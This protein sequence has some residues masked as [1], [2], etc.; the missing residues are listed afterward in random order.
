[1]DYAYN[2][3][4]I[5][6]R[7]FRDGPLAE[8]LC[9]YDP[10]TTAF[11]KCYDS[12]DI[13]V[14]ALRG[15]VGEK[16]RRLLALLKVMNSIGLISSVKLFPRNAPAGV[17]FPHFFSLF[18][19]MRQEGDVLNRLTGHRVVEVPE[20]DELQGEDYVD[21]DIS[22]WNPRFK[23]HE[24]LSS[25]VFEKV[26]KGT[27]VSA[28]THYKLENDRLMKFMEETS[29]F[30]N[31]FS[32]QAY[33][34]R[35][36]NW[37]F[38]DRSSDWGINKP[39][40]KKL[41]DALRPDSSNEATNDSRKQ[42]AVHLLNN[43]LA[44]FMGNSSAA[45]FVKDF[46]E[47]N[48][49]TVPVIRTM[50]KE[51]V[52]LTMKPYFFITINA[53]GKEKINYWFD[54]WIC[55]QDRAVISNSYFYPYPIV[56]P[57]CFVPE[58]SGKY[59]V[60]RSL[61]DFSG[62]PWTV[63]EL[64]EAGNSEH[65]KLCIKHFQ[66]IIKQGFCKEKNEADWTY[67]FDWFSYICQSKK[68]SKICV[69][70]KTQQGIGKG[71]VGKIFS[72]IFGDHAVSMNAS[73]FFSQFMSYIE[74]LK[75]ILL[76]ELGSTHGDMEMFRH[77][78]TEENSLLEGKFKAKKSADLKFEIFATT[79]MDLYLWKGWHADT[80][81]FFITEGEMMNAEQLKAWKS[82]MHQ[83]WIDILEHPLYDDLGVKA[84]FHWLISRDLSHF[85]PINSL[86]IT[87][88]LKGLMSDSLPVVHKWWKCVLERQTLIHSQAVGGPINDREWLWTDLYNVFTGDTS[89][90]RVGQKR[91]ALPDPAIF[92]TELSQIAE[93]S[94]V[95]EKSNAFSFKAW[96]AQFEKWGKFYRNIELLMTQEML[97]EIM[98]RDPFLRSYD[99]KITNTPV[100][101]VL[102]HYSVD[103]LKYTIAK[104]QEFIARGSATRVILRKPPR[105]PEEAEQDL[106]SF[107]TTS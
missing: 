15:F 34:A 31:V 95:Q 80:R 57:D 67:L 49:K 106:L 22:L 82:W 56:E 32:V 30:N 83:V 94:N 27:G 9:V 13:Q 1:M 75:F 107:P 69:I 18:E 37:N 5:F 24:S 58:D 71:F 81:R 26:L 53:K 14:C 43:V 104:L 42:S 28:A 25:H 44:L 23:S 93:L 102:N 38:L 41:L 10:D 63:A 77:F 98:N 12:R 64:E 8:Y 62:Y 60:H 7:Y 40:I 16:S 33:I 68:R 97:A 79:N 21:L 35:R 78:L 61:N 20:T 87:D 103:E 52:S 55:H 4:D 36:G 99:D 101:S 45:F 19:G 89:F 54:I 84:I 3:E 96:P 66:R 70:V 6:D 51:D 29:N 39:V 73:S 74:S 91:K 50:R 46:E 72:R 2:R 17:T 48:G 90:F 65:G 59:Y 100:P 47:R 11:L 92:K 85:D 88:Y 105:K 86:V 76:D